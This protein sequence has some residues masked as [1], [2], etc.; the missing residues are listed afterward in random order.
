MNAVTALQK[1]SHRWLEGTTEKRQTR[2]TKATDFGD[3][4]T[5]SDE[6]RAAALRYAKAQ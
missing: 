2:A 5:I 3:I 1:L 6:G 4:A